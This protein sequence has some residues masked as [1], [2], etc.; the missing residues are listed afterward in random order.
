[1]TSTTPTAHAATGAS[2]TSSASSTSDTT[3]IYRVFIRATPQA[4]WDAITQPDWT[5]RFG[6]GLRDEIELRPGGNFRGHVN[7]EMI[8]MGMSGVVVDGEMIEVDPPR[9]LV[10]TWRMAIDPRMAAE[11]FTRLTYEI[12][13]G[14]GG[15]SRLSVIHDLSGRPAHAA[16]VA[17]DQ[18]GPGAGGGWTWILSD[19]KSLLENGSAM[20]APPQ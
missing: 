2:N 14:R 3:Q 11:G 13:E 15:V 9:R 4:I 1:M 19:L 20:V 18:Q 12:S 17:G 16:M 10:M 5:R 6:Y 7:D 8:A